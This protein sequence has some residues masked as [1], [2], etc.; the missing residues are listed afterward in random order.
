MSPASSTGT[1]TTRHRAGETR[2]TWLK[3]RWRADSSAWTTGA[4]NWCP[5]TTGCFPPNCRPSGSSIIAVAKVLDRPQLLGTSRHITQCFVDVGEEQWQQCRPF[6]HLQT[7][8]RRPDGT[9]HFHYFNP[10]GVEGP[11]RRDFQG[12]PRGRSDHFDE[13][14]WPV[15]SCEAHRASKPR[16]E[17]AIRF[18][19]P[20][21]R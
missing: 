8:G 20:P 18:D 1:Q 12:R 9:A 14:R 3:T 5:S 11:C 19:K 17:V 13:R 2:S 10:R 6:R 7:G 16:S 4:A 21:R 15:A